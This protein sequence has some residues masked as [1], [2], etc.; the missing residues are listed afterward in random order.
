MKELT[1]L[2]NESMKASAFHDYETSDDYEMMFFQEAR[3]KGLSVNE[4]EKLWNKL[5]MK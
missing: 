1:R 3:K 5:L 4:T 2:F